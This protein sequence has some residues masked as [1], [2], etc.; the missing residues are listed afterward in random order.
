MWRRQIGVRY[1]M[2]NNLS[3]LPAIFDLRLSQGKNEIKMFLCYSYITK[4]NFK[5]EREGRFFVSIFM[6]NVNVLHTKSFLSFDVENIVIFSDQFCGRD[7]F[8]ENY[9]W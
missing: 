9:N 6:F 8:L 1:Q 4:S 7:K 3:F 5:R 2:E